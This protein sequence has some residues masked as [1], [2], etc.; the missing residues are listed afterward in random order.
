MTLTQEAP[1]VEE[2]SSVELVARTIAGIAQIGAASRALRQAGLTAS[3][4]ANRITTGGV[5]A[6]LHGVNGHSWWTVFASDG[7]PPVWSVGTS[8]RETSDWIGCVE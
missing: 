1:A 7:T 6:H 4:V 5:E 8:G 3:I 2:V